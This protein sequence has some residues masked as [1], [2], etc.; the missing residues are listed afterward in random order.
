MAH[1]HHDPER[2]A[3]S[4]VVGTVEILKDGEP[5]AE[6]RNALKLEE[7]GYPPRYYVPAMDVRTERLVPS[8]TR[9]R[10]PFKGL[11]EYFHFET[12]AGLLAD[13]AWS[14]P[15]PV[16]EVR[17]LAGHIAFHQEALDPVRIDGAP[18]NVS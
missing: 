4:P 8:E 3:I 7:R 14:Y 16:A 12:E 18:V 17:E 15:E 1:P 13:V 2:I 5:L 9:T 6:S 10:C 11:A